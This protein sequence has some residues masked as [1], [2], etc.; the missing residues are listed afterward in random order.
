MSNQKLDIMTKLRELQREEPPPED[1]AVATLSDPLHAVEKVTKALDQWEAI[2]REGGVADDASFASFLKT[3]RRVLTTQMTTALLHALEQLEAKLADT[4]MLTAKDLANVV[5]E[6]GRQRQALT[7]TDAPA[8]TTPT[9]EA[10]LDAR[11]QMLETELGPDP[12]TKH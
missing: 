11:I 3:S 6:L 9:T 7:K 2:I 10:E 12:A 8:G 1:L 5:G 4:S